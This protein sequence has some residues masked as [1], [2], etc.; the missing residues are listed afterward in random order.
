ML[1]FDIL[2]LILFYPFIYVVKCAFKKLL[3]LIGLRI[4]VEK[5]LLHSSGYIHQ[6]QR[7][8]SLTHMGYSEACIIYHSSHSDHNENKL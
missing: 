7:W 8:P 2:N 4:I 5:I 6:S 1:S 3:S